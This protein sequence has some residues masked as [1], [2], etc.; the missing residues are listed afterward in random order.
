MTTT[1]EPLDEPRAAARISA[2]VGR[3]PDVE[4]GG[5][6]FGGVEF[7]LE[8]GSRTESATAGGLQKRYQNRVAVGLKPWYS[9]PRTAPVAGG[10]H[11]LER[12]R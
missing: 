11:G 3:W 4:V 12:S 1:R 6:R 2:I 8:K 10:S 7:R 5:H 9:S